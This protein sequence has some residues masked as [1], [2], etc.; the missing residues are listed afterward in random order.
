MNSLTEDTFLNFIFDRALTDP[1]SVMRGLASIGFDFQLNNCIPETHFQWNLQQDSALVSHANWLCHSLNLSPLHL[2]PSEIILSDD[3]LQEYSNLRDI[4]TANVRSRFSLIQSI[5]E[6]IESLLDLTDFRPDEDPTSNASVIGRAKSLIFFDVKSKYLDKVLNATCTANPELPAPTILVNPVE[7]IG[8][9][10][11]E[12]KGTWFYQSMVQLSQVSSLEL[13]VPLASGSDPH[14]PFLVKMSGE[15]VEGH[16]GSFRHLLA[17]L[18]DELHGP[19]LSLFM[20]YMGE[21]SFKGRYIL[22]PGKNI[23]CISLFIDVVLLIIS[24]I[25]NLCALTFL[26]INCCESN[27]SRNSEIHHFDVS[28]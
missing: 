14:Y 1:I 9:S 26:F 20:P 13:C 19:V 11:D 8:R 12:I 4:P 18:V 27:L 2:D 3:I 10:I 6:N 15:N 22:R 7:A 25:W 17:K 23:I 21:G 16:S 24:G 28:S 5:N